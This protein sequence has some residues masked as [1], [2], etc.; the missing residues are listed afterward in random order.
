MEPNL[1][2]RVF[3]SLTGKQHET[4]RLAASHLTSKQIAKE[5]GVAPITI[6]KRIEGVRAR[7]SGI[8]RPDL[9]RLYT[10]WLATYDQA[11]DDPSILGQCS[12]NGAESWSQPADPVLNFADSLTF[13]ERAGWERDQVWLR[14]GLNPS[15]LGVSGKLL[16]ILGG[17]VAIMMVAVLSVAFADALMSFF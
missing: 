17:A 3:D 14:P 4:L 1:A 16:V 9:L 13:D 15:D 10:K 6:D 11:I 5:L 8:A 7:L 2:F 12:E